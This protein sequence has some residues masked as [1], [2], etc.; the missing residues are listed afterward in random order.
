M[1]R[2]LLLGVFHVAKLVIIG[3]PLKQE[4]ANFLEPV[5]STV[6]QGVPLAHVL[7]IDICTASEKERE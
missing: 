7:G 1:N 6:M 5:I 2:L 4:V 3:L